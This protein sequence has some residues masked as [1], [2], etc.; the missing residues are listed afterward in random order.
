[1][2]VINALRDL[3]LTRTYEILQ[4]LPRRQSDTYEARIA[5]ARQQLTEELK[6]VWKKCLE[7]IDFKLPLLVMDEA[8]HLK[9][10]A[11]DYPVSFRIP[12]PDRMPMKF[13]GACLAASLNGCSF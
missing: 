3:D 5:S 12:R 4:G 9:T 11:R 10:L 8:H 2:A 13:L 7:K 6:E 1:M